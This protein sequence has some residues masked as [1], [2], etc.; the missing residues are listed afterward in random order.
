MDEPSEMTMVPAYYNPLLVCVL[1][2]IPGTTLQSVVVL[3]STLAMLAAYGASRA[4]SPARIATGLPGVIHRRRRSERFLELVRL[5]DDAARCL[6]NTSTLVAALRVL[7][8]YSELGAPLFRL[9]ARTS[10]NRLFAK[11]HRFTNEASQRGGDIRQT[12]T[13]RRDEPEH[14]QQPVSKTTGL[15]GRSERET[16][17]GADK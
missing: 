5:L 9:P 6:P 13:V 1:S 10:F 7:R 16:G 8:L 3:Y 12:D 11:Q 2:M 15:S 17:L 14:L 4:S